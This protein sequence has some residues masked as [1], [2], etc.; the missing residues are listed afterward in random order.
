MALAWATV[1]RITGRLSAADVASIVEEVRA[2][3][4][5]AIYREPQFSSRLVDLVAEET[6][7]Q[8]LE[9]Y[10]DAFGGEAQTYESMMRANAAAIVAGLVP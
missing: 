2:H 9:L 10:S 5:P 4:V 6:G 1:G 8:V 3:E 7:A